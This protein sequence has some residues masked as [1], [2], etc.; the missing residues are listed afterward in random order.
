[1]AWA[2]TA[3]KANEGERAQTDWG[4]D[5]ELPAYK[6]SFSGD[7]SRPG[8]DD[9]C[10]DV[11]EFGRRAGRGRRAYLV[12]GYLNELRP[13]IS[14]GSLYID[15]GAAVVDGWWCPNLTAAEQALPDNGTSYA[16]ISVTAGGVPDFDTILSTDGGLAD[17]EPALI[18]CEVVQAA[19]TVTS[20]KDL[21]H[22][23]MLTRGDDVWPAVKTAYAQ[24]GGE[25]IYSGG[26]DS[27]ADFVSGKW[28]ASSIVVNDDRGGAVPCTFSAAV[29][30]GTSNL[31]ASGTYDLYAVIALGAS[32]PQ[33]AGNTGWLP[34]TIEAYDDA[35]DPP[36]NALLL[37]TG[38]Y[39]GTT[40]SDFT[41][42]ASARVTSQQF[43]DGGG[44]HVLTVERA[45]L[46]ADRTYTIP[47]A[48]AAADFVMDEGAQT[49]GGVK[50][51]TLAPI[52]SALTASNL[53]VTDGSKALA[54]LAYVTLADYFS[55]SVGSMVGWAATPTG[56]LYY[57]KVGKVVKVFGRVT[58]TSNTTAA[59]QVPLPYVLHSSIS[60]IEF[61]IRAID[62]ATSSVDPGMAYMVA[63][64]AN[65]YVGKT[66]AGGAW[67]ASGTCTI[68]F[69]VQYP[70]NS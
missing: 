50:T 43:T 49:L 13:Y 19:G 65:L 37:G 32:D 22:L 34:I 4:T 59:R 70:T 10:D 55:T 33:V 30:I 7:T 61:P 21:R 24:L 68:T 67:T 35:A 23:G 5:P 1:M 60:Q 63:G 66:L 45:D 39:T 47:D 38:S 46:A 54:S 42:D 62:N 2:T 29:T 44:D 64:D 26:A 12:P 58:G 15:T 53:V 48:G 18:I 20:I 69:F 16:Y 52:L 11:E 17:I 28:P 8:W 6:G 40:L 14:G 31:A 57:Q 41:I 36:L 51:F 25:G 27:E 9:L 3:T 56:T